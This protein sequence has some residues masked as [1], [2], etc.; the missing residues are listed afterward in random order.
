MAEEFEDFEGR[1]LDAEFLGIE[2]EVG[3]LRFFEAAVLAG[4]LLHLTGGSFGV[5]PLRIAGFAGG[6]V[7]LHVDLDKILAENTAGEISQMAHGGDQRAKHDH[8]VV[9]EDFGQLGG[10]PNVLEAIFVAE[11]E[12]A[13]ETRTEVVAIKPDH[14]P[15]LVVENVLQGVGD[16]RLAR[17]RKAAEPE[18]A[19][20]LLQ[21][22]LL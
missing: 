21:K 17:T 16:R 12:V 22:G 11:A 1:I 2:D 3:L 6:V 18:D 8:A 19:A 5:E 14:E 15:A 9:R 7:C 20:F 4:E 10:A 13:V